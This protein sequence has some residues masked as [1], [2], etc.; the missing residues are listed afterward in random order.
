MRFQLSGWYALCEKHFRQAKKLRDGKTVFA[1]W[2]NPV[3]TIGRCYFCDSVATREFYPFGR[4]KAKALG[5][6]KK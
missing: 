2:S 4:R 3:L 6:I 1:G 5:V